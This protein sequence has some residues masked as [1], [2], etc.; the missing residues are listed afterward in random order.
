LKIE[1]KKKNGSMRLIYNPKEKKSK[2]F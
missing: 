1:I 2:K